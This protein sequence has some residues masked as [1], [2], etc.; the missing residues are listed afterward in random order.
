MDAYQAQIT[1]RVAGLLAE[2]DAV[3]DAKRDAERRLKE[4]TDAIKV[5]LTTEQTTRQ[6]YR[7][8]PHERYAIE[9]PALRTPL[10]LRWQPGNRVDVTALREKEPEIAKAFEV[11]DNKWVLER[12]RGNK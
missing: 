2:Y 11:P 9:H 10:M 5:E 8:V 12:K 7:D 3:S 6:L 4:I 1:E